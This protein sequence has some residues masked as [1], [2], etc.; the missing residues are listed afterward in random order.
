MMTL[1]WR[2]FILAFILFGCSPNYYLKRAER[3]TRKAI[4]LG[5]KVKVDTVYQDV[6]LFLPE[7]KHDT[8]VRYNT[9]KD[10]IRIETEN[11]VEKTVY[12]D[13]TI[14]RDTVK[15]NVPVQIIRNISSGITFG[16]VVMS[17]IISAVI[18]GFLL[19][20]LYLKFKKQSK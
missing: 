7:T 6:Q 4:E 3:A 11:E 17:S 5:A 12:L 2:Y 1:I 20:F 18:G 19:F 10:T 14:K 16:S 8:I 13:G 15:V 9:L